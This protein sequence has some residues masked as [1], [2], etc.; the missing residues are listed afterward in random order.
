MSRLRSGPGSTITWRLSMGGVAWAA[1]RCRVFTQVWFSLIKRSVG[2][3]QG[4]AYGGMQ[5]ECSTHERVDATVLTHVTGSAHRTH[6]WQFIIQWVSFLCLAVDTCELLSTGSHICRSSP[7]AVA[8]NQHLPQRRLQAGRCNRKVRRHTG[9]GGRSHSRRRRQHCCGGS[10]K[11][12]SKLK[13]VRSFASMIFAPFAFQRTTPETNPI[14]Q[15]QTTGATNE[16]VV[17][18]LA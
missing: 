2:L 10:R 15:G 14:G 16:L 17:T 12:R 9:C 4:M 6:T 7:K 8:C 5:L 18:R 1:C 13:T 11:S 3:G